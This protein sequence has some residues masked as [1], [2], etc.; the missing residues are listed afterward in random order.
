MGLEISLSTRTSGQTEPLR[1]G[2]RIL[3][4]PSFFSRPRQRH[5][6]MRAIPSACDE[7]FTAAQ[8]TASIYSSAA[9]E[10]AFPSCSSAAQRP[11]HPPPP[12]SRSIRTSPPALKLPFACGGPL[13]SDLPTAWRTASR[14]HDAGD[15]RWSCARSMPSLPAKPIAR[16]REDCS[17]NA[18]CHPGPPGRHM[19]SGT[20]PF[21]WFAP[22]STLCVAATLIFFAT[23]PVDGAER[24]SWGWRN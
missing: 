3:L 5:S 8:A 23:T 9:L 14:R 16:S 10:I 19:T 18:A 6:A 13:V 7:G 12:S 2:C 4:L 17:A 11:R 1:F 20:E 22:G 24:T 21:G 15:L